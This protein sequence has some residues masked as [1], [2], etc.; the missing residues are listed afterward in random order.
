[1]FNQLL[2]ARLLQE[3]GTGMYFILIAFLL[4]L[5]FVI[6][7]FVKRNKNKDD[8]KKMISLANETS[9]IALVIGCLCSMLGIINLFDMVEALGDVEPSIFSASL[10]VSL[11]TITFGLFSIALARIGILIYKW[12]QPKS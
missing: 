1:M 11:L 9:I 6:M 5:F 7:A 8:A 12:T 2:F 3:G 4:S 10:K